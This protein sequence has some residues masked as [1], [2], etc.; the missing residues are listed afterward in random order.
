V[1]HALVTGATGM[2]GSY[3]VERLLADGWTV[4]ALVREPPRAEWLVRRGVALHPGDTLDSA[5]FTHAATASDVVFHAA[6]A[7]APRGGWSAFRANVEGTRN[8]IEAARGAGARLLHVSSVAVYGP[9]TRFRADGGPTDESTPLAPLPS[10]AHYAR[11]KRESESAVLEAHRQGRVWATAVRPDVIY[12]RRDRQFVPR[13]ARLF[14][15]GLAPAIGSGDNTLAIVHAASVADGAVRAATSDAAGGKAYNV[16]NDFDV[17]VRD[18]VRFAA[19][20]L[21]RNVRLVRIPRPLARAGIAALSA[22]AGLVGGS[23]RRALLASS[24]HFLSRDNPFS[25]E[26]A[27]RELGWTPPLRAEE[28]VVD[29]FRWWKEQR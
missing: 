24:F 18:F 14:S 21:G 6:A 10:G 29:A 19:V 13:T 17:T 16:A 11:S 4:R 25:S 23:G 20:G 1:P 8:A 9:G 15:L 28:A 5:T 7:I 26:L 12:G 3:I 27:R 2:V 22:A